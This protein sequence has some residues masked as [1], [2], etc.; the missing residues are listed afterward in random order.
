M[1]FIIA[2]LAGLGVAYFLYSKYKESSTKVDELLASLP[3]QTPSTHEKVMSTPVV[4]PVE[5][6]A[7]VE[8]PVQEP[9]PAP[10]PVVETKPKAP[11]ITA[12]KKSPAKPKPAGQKKAKVK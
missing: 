7:V 2:V 10:A 4:K 12:K 5:V 11:A 3:A 6:V 1:E 9:A 8:T